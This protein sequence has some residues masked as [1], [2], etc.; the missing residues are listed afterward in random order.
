M[1]GWDEI[2]P[3]REEDGEARKGHLPRRLLAGGGQGE[4]EQEWREEGGLE[5]DG[6]DVADGPQVQEGQ[7]A[8]TQ[9]QTV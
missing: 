6:V 3:E 9:V 7:A 8:G 2:L 1:Q 5:G 4:A